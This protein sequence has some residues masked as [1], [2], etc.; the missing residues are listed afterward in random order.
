M[1]A[2][3]IKETNE[4]SLGMFSQVDCANQIGADMLDVL[5]WKCTET[6]LTATSVTY[7]S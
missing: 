7:I 2:Y 4:L 1:V 5:P 3:V 6:S